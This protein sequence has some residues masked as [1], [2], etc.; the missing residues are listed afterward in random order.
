[1]IKSATAISI[2]LCQFTILRHRQWLICMSGSHRI[3]K[4]LQKC[5]HKCSYFQS[6]KRELIVFFIVFNTIYF[7]IGSCSCMVVL[8]QEKRKSV[9]VIVEQQKQLIKPVVRI[10]EA[11]SEIV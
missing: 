7:N 9:T 6:Q 2:N 4:R 5:C 10:N 11:I 1:M 8:L 3:W